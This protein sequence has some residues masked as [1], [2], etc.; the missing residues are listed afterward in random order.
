MYFN[1]EWRAA[2]W[3]VEV[4]SVTPWRSQLNLVQNV[5]LASLGHTRLEKKFKG[6]VRNNREKRKPSIYL[7]QR[8]FTAGNWWHGGW[9][10]IEELISQ[11]AEGSSI[12]RLA[13]TRSCCHTWARGTEGRWSGT[14]THGARMLEG[15]WNHTRPVQWD[16]EPLA[17]RRRCC[18]RMLPEAQRGEKYP[19]FSVFPVFPSPASASLWQNPARRQGTSESGKSR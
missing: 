16:L 1:F 8:K 10:W 9:K 13:T 18:Y 19:G 3:R 5:T 4:G 17:Q 6:W 7:N 12:Q 11:K 2:Y 14:K 15:F